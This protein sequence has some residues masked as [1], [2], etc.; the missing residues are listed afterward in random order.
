MPWGLPPVVLHLDP[1]FSRR[2]L[3]ALMVFRGSLSSSTASP[4]LRL[5]LHLITVLY[6]WDATG[7]LHKVCL[8][9]GEKLYFVE[10]HD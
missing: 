2:Y 9:A 6:S 1:S 8:F 4:P 5:H 7:Y 3:I 10:G